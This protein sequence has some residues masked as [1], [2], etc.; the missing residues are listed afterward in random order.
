M[1]RKRRT[2]L[3]N[4]CRTIVQAK[5][6]R[7][8]SGNLRQNAILSRDTHNGFII[9]VD[10]NAGRYGDMLDRGVVPGKGQ[11]WRGWWA[12]ARNAVAVYIDSRKNN[13]KSALRSSQK[14]VEQTEADTQER[15]VTYIRNVRGT[16][17]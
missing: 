3:K 12:K 9:Y 17:K 11:D 6:I 16:T 2:N 14:T 10:D 5:V 15:Q 4:E 7:D 13:R 1:A 8:K